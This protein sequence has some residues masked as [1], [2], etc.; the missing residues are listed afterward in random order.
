[1]R[2][3]FAGIAFVYSGLMKKIARQAN[4]KHASDLRQIQDGE[5]SIICHDTLLCNRKPKT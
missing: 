5:G 2:P 1:M 3:I 4:R